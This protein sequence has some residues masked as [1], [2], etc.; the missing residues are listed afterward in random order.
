MPKRYP[1]EAHAPVDSLRRECVPQLMKVDVSWPR[2]AF[3][4][5]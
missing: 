1:L 3:P 2:T 5:R 4:S